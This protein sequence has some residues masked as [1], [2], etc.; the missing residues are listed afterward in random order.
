[1]ANRPDAP[2]AAAPPAAALQHLPLMVLVIATAAVVSLLGPAA[3]V[4]LCDQ[5]RLVLMLLLAAWGWGVWPAG[6]LVG[7]RPR[8]QRTALAI[9]LG[10]GILGILTLIVGLLGM[11][12]VGGWVLLA[13]GGL[14][15]V[16]HARLRGTRDPQGHERSLAG[17]SLRAT[18]GF[19]K[20]AAPNALR[21]RIIAGALLLVLSVP[22]GVGAFCATLPPGLLWNEEAGGYDV[23]EYHLQVPREWFDAGRIEFLPHNV[24]ASFPQ[25]I[26]ML[27]LLL[28]HLAGS[29]LGAAIAAELLHLVCGAVAVVLLAGAAPPG[30]PRAAVALVAGSVPWLGYLGALAYVELGVLMYAAGAA[31]LVLDAAAAPR[32]SWRPLL[33]AG[34]LAGFAAG[35]K[36]T[37]LVFVSVGLA[38]AWLA[39]GSATVRRR[40]WGGVIFAAAAAAAFAPWM[41]RNAVFTGNP[42]YPFAYAWFGGRDWSP[43]QDRQWA[44]GHRVPAEHDSPAARLRTAADE[45]VLA[46]KFGVGIWGAAALGLVLARNRRVLLSTVWLAV[47]VFAWAALTHMPGRFAVVAVVPLALLFAAGLTATVQRAGTR[48]GRAAAVLAGLVAVTAG[49]LGAVALAREYGEHAAW[50]GKRGVGLDELPGQVAVMAAANPLNALPADS[51]VR[52]VGE[53]RALYLRPRVQYTV[54]FSRDPWLESAADATPGAA[55]EWLRSHGVTHVVF[56]WPEIERLRRTYGFAPGVTRSWAAALRT[57]GLRPVL[58]P[59]ESPVGEI[60][61]LEVVAE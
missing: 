27:Y 38:A 42:V 44:A 13:G 53:A 1:M 43:V 41:I 14:L 3:W 18:D 11:L 24:Y 19:S 54:A 31:L 60:E 12:R 34:L 52:L 9:A 45:L 36:Y 46:G 51:C 49:S 25:Q 40:M 15:L 5:G 4:T 37:A 58:L 29:P 22:L 56:S 48:G 28:M 7:D 30:W 26:E 2:P 59:G 32:A 33:A 39:A 21:D 23:L 20:P 35:C 6:W 50:F 57:A 55:V 17:F 10:L 47:I 61:V 8:A 16:L